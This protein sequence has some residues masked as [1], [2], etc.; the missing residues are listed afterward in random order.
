MLSTPARL[1]A[2][3]RLRLF[4]ALSAPL[5]GLALASTAAQAAPAP[6]NGR[7]ATDSLSLKFSGGPFTAPNQTGTAGDPTC[8]GAAA[9]CDDFALQLDL[10]ADY[11]ATHPAATV[12]ISTAFATSADYDIYLLDVAG[13]V[14]TKSASSAEPEVMVLSSQQGLSNYKVRIVPFDATMGQTYETTITLVPGDAAGTGGGGSS[15]SSSGGSSTGG[16]SSGGGVG[17]TSGPPNTV[18]AGV[19]RYY[20]YAPPA[21]VGENSG[22]PSLGYN[23]LTKRAM[24]ISGLQTLRITFPQNLAPAGSVPEACDAQWDDVSYV[25]HQHQVARPHPLHRSRHRPHLCLA[26]QQ[27]GAAGQPGAGRRE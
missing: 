26:A 10:P 16:S 14:V 1:C 2:A 19:P 18:G 24:Y 6:V 7:I 27:R 11:K 5:F 8:Q 22:E 21:A 20:N 12:T 17:T 9:P 23:L 3:S 13:T 15:S 4:G 25:R